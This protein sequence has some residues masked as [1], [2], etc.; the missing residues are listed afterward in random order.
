MLIID[1]HVEHIL[2]KQKM[3][4]LQEYVLIIMMALF[5]KEIQVIPVLLVVVNVLVTGLIK[6]TK[7]FGNFL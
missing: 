4:K 2:L 6:E 5:L 7:L 3:V 1:V